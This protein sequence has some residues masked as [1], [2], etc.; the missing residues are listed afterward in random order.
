MGLRR[1]IEAFGT[2]RFN[3]LL[4]EELLMDPSIL[5]LGVWDPGEIEID[6]LSVEDRGDAI[7]ADLVVS[8]CPAQGAGCCATGPDADVA[9]RILFLIDKAH[10]VGFAREM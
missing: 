10:G 2:T 9:K 8:Y 5:R 1:A 3:E 6:V 7:E 4:I